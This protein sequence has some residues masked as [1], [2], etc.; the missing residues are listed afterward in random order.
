MAFRSTLDIDGRIICSSEQPYVIAELSGNHKGSLNEAL[1]LID[2]A[3]ASGADAIKIQTY[4]PDTITLN[5]DSDE[6]K[7]DGGIWAGRTL[8]ELYEEAHTPWEWHEALFN[9]AREKGVTL[10]SSP[11]DESAIDLLEALHC[12][13]YKIASFEIND[14]GLITAA[15]KTGK[16][17]IMS[18][19]LATLDEIEEAVEAVSSAGGTQLALLHCI[20]GY[21]T[22]IED[23]NLLTISDLKSRFNIP[24][25]LSDHTV[26]NTA[27]ITAIAL[28]ARIIEKHFTI[29]KNSDSVD[30]KFSI[31]PAT[32]SRLKQESIRVHNALGKVNYDIKP[33]EA[34]GRDFRRSLY[35][36]KPI[37]KGEIFTKENVVSVRPAKGLH[38]RYLNQVIGQVASQDIAFGEPLSNEHLT[39]PIEES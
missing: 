12:P 23:C 29:D 18:T 19:G 13:A 16:P 10:F 25:G 4:R 14:I 20:S 37:S 28:G 1:A 39:H 3:A 30:A 24:I 6:F 34:G 5:H 26:D 35:I 32:F 31:D 2:A 38:T 36:A 7:I 21:P 15:A 8:Y 33:S 27:S 17:I 9:R 22:P 11:F